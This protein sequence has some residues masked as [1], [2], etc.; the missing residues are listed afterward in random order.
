MVPGRREWGK[1]MVNACLYPHAI[2]EVLKIRLSERNYEDRI[3]W[4]YGRSGHVHGEKCL[5]FST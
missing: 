4:H 3:A 1:Q 2:E 5:P